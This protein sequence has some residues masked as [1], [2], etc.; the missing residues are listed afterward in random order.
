[1]NDFGGYI[2]SDELYTDEMREDKMVYPLS[3]IH[4][5]APIIV[6]LSEKNTGE[7]S[8]KLREWKN[9]IFLSMPQNGNREEG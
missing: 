9:V 3:R 4:R 6:A 5:D 2:I 8:G 7:V 1:M